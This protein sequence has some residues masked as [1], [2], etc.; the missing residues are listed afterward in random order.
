MAIHTETY[1]K[2]QQ[3][4]KALGVSVSTIKRWVDSGALRATRTLGKHRLIRRDEIEQF[5]REQGLRFREALIPGPARVAA[6]DTDQVENL[7]VALRRGRHSE[8]REILLATH[9]AAGTAV[10]A[11]QLI[12]PALE[13]IGLDW[14]ARAIDVFQEHRATRIVK[15]VIW[16]LIH[17]TT[18]AA[19]AIGSAP[20]ALGAT[21]EDDPYLLP[22]LLCELALREL[23]WDVMN[24]GVNLPLASLAKAVRAHRPALVWLSVS[25]LEDPALF[26]REY[27][28]FH[29]IASTTGAA[30]VVGGRALLPELRARIVAASFGE[31]VAHLAEFARRLR[32]DAAAP[33]APDFSNPLERPFG[34]TDP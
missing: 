25:H 9:D 1:L 28:A 12:R 2:T 19:P 27:M 7:M 34:R 17:R 11:D 24:L 15:Q 16:E 5:A 22:G 6:V 20:L 3:V 30:V 32:P 18:S 29:R 21:P 33:K 8:A 14:E 10:L 31:R 13:Q 4:A 23:G 26:V